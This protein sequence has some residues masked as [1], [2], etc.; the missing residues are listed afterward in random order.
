M[1]TTPATGFPTALGAFTLGR[2]PLRNRILVGA[3]GT[4]YAR[5]G[6]PTDRYA[7]YV[8][9][10]ARG[11]V[12]LIVT[13]GTHVHPTSAGAYLIDAWRRNGADQV[14]AV[15]DAVHAEGGAIFAQ[16]MHCGRQQEPL[17]SG[18]AAWG[19]SS[20]G[21]PAHS[22][23]PH[24]MTHPE[25]LAMIEAFARSAEIAADNGYD[26]V[27]LHCGHGYL[28]E[29][30]LSPW[31]NHR[32]DRWGGSHENRV[33]FARSVVHAVLDRVADR[34]EVGIRINAYET[35]PGGLDRDECLDIIGEL[36]A[37]GVTYVSVT[38]GQH[39]RPFM[40]VPP[41]G[42]PT[43]P[44]RDEIARVKRTVDCA[45]FA[46]H[47]V[48]DLA[49][50]E[51]ILAAGDA[52]MVNMVRAHIADPHLVNKANE[53]RA[54]ETRPCIGCVQGCRH[55]LVAGM[56]VGCLVN[57]RAG[58]ERLPVPTPRRRPR[59]IAVVGGG[60]AGM[61]T[62]VTTAERGDEVV[63]FE[64]AERLGGLFARSAVL[65]ERAE[66]A[67]FTDHL[68]RELDRA[69]V[70]TELGRAVSADDLAGFDKV[71]VA[72]GGVRRPLD[73][74]EFPE[75]TV[76]LLDLDTALDHSASAG[77]HVLV[78]DRGDA[79]NVALL[80]ARRF[81]DGGAASV[82]IVD[83]VGVI[84]RKLDLLNKQWMTRELDPDR[85]RQAPGVTG[86]EIR[87]ATAS[88]RSEG[89]AH[90]VPDLAS[91][92]FLEPLSAAD[93]NPWLGCAP[94]VEFV[95]D[96]DAPGLAVEIVHKAYEMA[97][98]LLPGPPEPEASPRPAR[99]I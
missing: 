18:R 26:G 70:R 36:A 62:A 13:E 88:F 64:R 96:C 74:A 94:E 59:R 45:V 50:A 56:P 60:I 69:G 12:G 78:V 23:V 49:D 25:I 92:V 85:V 35:V 27:E 34:I 5:D 86:L 98:G 7:A 37:Q 4:N 54:P 17:L 38:A 97:A 42:V 28:I 71:V 16:L 67:R 48:R 31:A 32:T 3:H 81:Q 63:L 91:V 58:Y 76:S 61:Q 55:Q 24:A 89:W 21:D 75:A 14:R 29:E 10:R 40:V 44:F 66:V 15:T 43:L 33:R 53:G 82:T 90:S 11:G 95:G 30:F 51:E 41:A 8:A 93:P 79:H 83:T 68:A 72:T 65:P 1:S 39:A 57:P 6:L 87:G 22:T 80:L 47:R 46:S 19:P 9:E 20:I 73:P 84:G 52:D 2:L 99:R 77:D